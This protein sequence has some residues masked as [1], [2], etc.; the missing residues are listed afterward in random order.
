M[1]GRVVGLFASVVIL[2]A[3]AGCGGGET[4]D[5]STIEANL[6]AQ[7]EPQ[8][9]VTLADLSCPADGP[10]K[11]GATIEC[12][13]TAADGDKYVFSVKVKDASGNLAW[14]STNLNP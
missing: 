1:P 10:V 5:V 3:V 12:S 13:G 9:K 8:T 7:F 6:K 11:V 14:Q 2:A 4:V